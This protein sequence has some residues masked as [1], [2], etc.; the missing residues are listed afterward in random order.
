[1]SYVVERASR[2]ITVRFAKA[3]FSGAP[4]VGSPSTD[5]FAPG[6]REKSPAG[7]SRWG[8]VAGSEAN[9]GTGF[10]IA[11]GAAAAVDETT[12]AREGTMPPISAVTTTTTARRCHPDVDMCPRLPYELH[13][14]AEHDDLLCPDGNCEG[15]G[16]M[17]K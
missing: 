13:A 16:A 1:L 17:V 15:N 12:G 7:V 9:G 14:V 2:P 4:P 8:C 10:A 11:A 3:K 6:A 5:P